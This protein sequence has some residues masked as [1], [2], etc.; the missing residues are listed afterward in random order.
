M[1]NRI[2]Q[3][4][5]QA[6]WRI[7]LQWI[8]LFLL[9]LVLV[10][11]ITGIYLSISAQ[12]ASA[13]RS[14]QALESE[15]DNINNEIASLTTDLAVAQSTDRMFARAGELGFALREPDQALYLEIPGYDP[16]A[17]LVLAPPRINTIIE[18]P[19]VRQSY[20]LSLW[21]WLSET[22]WNISPNTIQIE[23]GQTP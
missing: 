19:T 14:I 22:I 18:A 7:Q 11:S 16:D 6:P 8:G 9:G 10:A 21:D 12:A 13:G 1:K 15:I 20:K 23:G 4:Y 2:L 5:R 17:K 3:A